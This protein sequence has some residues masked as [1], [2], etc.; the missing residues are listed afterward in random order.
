MATRPHRHLGGTTQVGTTARWRDVM[1]RQEALAG[2]P[3]RR[4]H[5]QLAQVLRRLAP[6]GMINRQ[7]GA[8]ASLLA[9]ACN[10]PFLPQRSPKTMGLKLDAV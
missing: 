9:S 10:A 7:H 3:V 5:R 1:E 2:A 4:A 8:T 6:A